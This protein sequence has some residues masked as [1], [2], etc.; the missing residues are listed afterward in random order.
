MLLYGSGEGLVEVKRNDL[1]ALPDL[2]EEPP[3][4]KLYFNFDD[5]LMLI[6]NVAE[7]CHTLEQS[8]DEMEAADYE[9]IEQ[10]YRAMQYYRNKDVN[11][12]PLFQNMVS[13]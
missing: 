10:L 8:F 6:T 4:L 9:R 5:R 11:T 2:A 7:V 1:P 12:L 3:T 13:E